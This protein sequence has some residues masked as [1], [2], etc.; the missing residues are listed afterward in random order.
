MRP[1]LDTERIPQPVRAGVGLVAAGIDRAR[2][3]DLTDLA[4]V[5]VRGL[6]YI[7]N[8]R[9]RLE[10]TYQDL[11]NR[12][13]NVVAR[14]RGGTATNGSANG[15]AAA[16]T[17]APER[18]ATDRAKDRATDD[19]AT[20]RGPT[21]PEPQPPVDLG[22][23]TPGAT[24]SHDQLPL[25]DYDHLTLGSLRARLPKLDVIALTQLR[26]YERV[27]A[28][29]LPVLTMLDNRIAKLTGTTGT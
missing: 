6:G 2:H 19:S 10:R 26:D 13:E 23:A 24:L 15:S 7:A 3:I 20:G 8:A 9:E 17:T 14:W 16:T 28:N 12:G 22:G 18:P 5:P 1:A 25:D 21:L 11:T 27:H 29:R 4:T